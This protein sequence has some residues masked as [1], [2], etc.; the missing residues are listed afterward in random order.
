M[1]A[2]GSRVPLAGSGRFFEGQPKTVGSDGVP[3]C[4]RLERKFS[5]W[6]RGSVALTGAS[7]LPD[8]VQVPEQPLERRGTLYNKERLAFGIKV[9][10]TPGARL[11]QKLPPVTHIFTGVE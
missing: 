7:H 5:T 11:P 9:K 1:A 4:D 10:Q 2:P 3:C 6:R 8:D